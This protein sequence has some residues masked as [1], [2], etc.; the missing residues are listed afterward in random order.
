MKHFTQTL[1]FWQSRPLTHTPGGFRLPAFPHFSL[2]AFQRFSLVILGLSILP[3]FSPSL[4]A[5]RIKDLT[6]V[7]GGRD[8]QLVGY[9][10]VVGLAGDGDSTSIS[11]LRSVANALQR[12]GL[13]VPYDQIKVKNAASVMV[14]ADIGAFLRPGAR[15]DLVVASLGDAKSLQGGVLLQTPLLGADGRVYAVAQG[16]VAIGGFLGGTGGPGGSTVQ[17]NHPTVG[18]ISNGA[19]VEREIPT[20]FVGPQ[21]LHLLL[22]DPDFTSA[23]RMAKAINAVYPG[24]SDAQDP[25]TVAVRLP[26]EFKGHEVD[27]VSAVGAIEMA[28]DSVARIVINERTGTIVAT[29]TVRISQVAISHGSLTITV[30][31]SQGVSQPGAFSSGTTT[32]VQGTNTAVDEVKGGFKVVDEL[33][34]IERLAAA[35]NA[36][37]VSTREMTAIFQTLKRS[38][39]LQ[40]ELII[41]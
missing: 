16:P 18:T 39:A 24:T 8:N 13:V 32:V 26:A 19:I 37:G 34:S 38:G 29:S 28:P 27:Y 23:A 5:A 36:L 15:I 11:V 4:R 40:A 33:P 3:A 30:T 1:H 35:M 22:R 41:N 17:K 20:T 6:L 7:E 14:T 9:G 10:L 12:F 21:G 31:S 25:A 2:S